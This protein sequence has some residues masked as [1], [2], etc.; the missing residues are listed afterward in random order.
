MGRPAPPSCVQATPGACPHCS[1]RPTA[2]P[3]RGRCSTLRH[4]PLTNTEGSALSRW[5]PA[6]PALLPALRRCTHTS[7]RDT[8]EGRTHVH[9]QRPLPEEDHRS[10]SAP[11]ASLQRHG[12]AAPA[13]RGRTHEASRP[14]HHPVEARAP[15][16][17][18]AVRRARGPARG[19]TG[20]DRPHPA[21]R[22]APPP[23]ARRGRQRPAPHTVPVHLAATLLR[24]CPA[25]RPSPRRGTPPVPDRDTPLQNGQ[26]GGPGHAG[27]HPGP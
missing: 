16:P 15:R 22:R 1:A 11:C 3:S 25:L 17:H 18:C 8:G 9:K 4:C 7:H 24:W 2:P 6:S 23:Q 12:P 19:G 13:A 20:S 5:R 10:L 26:D 27:P 14:A 21:A